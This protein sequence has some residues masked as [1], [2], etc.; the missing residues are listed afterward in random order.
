M[1]KANYLNK[2]KASC[3]T[4]GGGGEGRPLKQFA[5]SET[6]APPKSWSENNR[7][8]SIRIEI[9]IKI[10]FSPEKVPE[11]AREVQLSGMCSHC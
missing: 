11:K 8:I 4:L 7:K 10:D 2:N 6:V 9:C 5:P 1:Q 3:L